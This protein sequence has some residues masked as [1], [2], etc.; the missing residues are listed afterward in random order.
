MGT[1]PGNYKT[2]LVFLNLSVSYE[3]R[4]SCLPSFVGAVTVIAT[5]TVIRSST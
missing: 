2:R 5:V 4:S 1:L 3:K